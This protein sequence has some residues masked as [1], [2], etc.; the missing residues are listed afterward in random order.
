MSPFFNENILTFL[1]PSSPKREMTLLREYLLFLMKC[2]NYLNLALLWS[3]CI[4]FLQSYVVISPSLLLSNILNNSWACCSVMSIDIFLQAF[5]RSFSFST[6]EGLLASAQNVLYP[7]E[8]LYPWSLIHSLIIFRAMLNYLAA[9]LWL[10]KPDWLNL[11]LR[12]LSKDLFVLSNI[13]VPNDLSRLVIDLFMLLSSI[14]KS[15]LVSMYLLA[16]SSISKNYWVLPDSLDAII[17]IFEN[18]LRLSEV[19]DIFPLN[20]R[21]STLRANTVL[22]SLWM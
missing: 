15:K 17:D 22:V 19:S 14:C 10:K 18:F 13:L 4:L 16:S 6:Y 8:E 9:F 11:M 12:L 21:S 7:S 20:L 3:K 5:Q 1:A 2:T